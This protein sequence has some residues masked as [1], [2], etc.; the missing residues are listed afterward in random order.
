MIEQ[1]KARGLFV[2]VAESLT[3]G[4]LASTLADTPGASGV[5]LGSIVSYQDQVK[6]ELLGVSR[7]L[8][9]AQSAVD[10]E[11]AIQMAI[12]VR[13]KFARAMGHEP[14]AV[15]GISTTGVAGPEPVGEKPVGEVYIGISSELG[16][17]VIALE[18]DGSRDEIRQ[19]TVERALELLREEI[20]RFSV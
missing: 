11:V 18:L 9:A 12:G 13:G 3:A 8:I 4:A 15:I 10:P 14:A 20:L 5:L 17:K 6:S 1:A 19:R 7:Q 2:A 16:D